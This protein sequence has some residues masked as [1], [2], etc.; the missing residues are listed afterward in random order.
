MCRVRIAS[1]LT[2]IG[3]LLGCSLF[4]GCQV[5]SRT[6]VLAMERREKL[7]EERRVFLAQGGRRAFGVIRK[8]RRLD[9]GQDGAAQ[10]PT[11]DP[12]DGSGGATTPSQRHPLAGGASQRS[13]STSM[14]E[15]VDDLSAVP[16]DLRRQSESGSLPV[17]LKA[18][19]ASDTRQ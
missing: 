8:P 9:F 1:S 5:I 14:V 18:L 7:C 13:D 6:N 3:T 19:Q 4:V 17:S 12:D 10:R 16:E 2:R 15:L 11:A